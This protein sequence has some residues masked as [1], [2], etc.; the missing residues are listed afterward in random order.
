MEVAS[1]SLAFK[2]KDRR[3]RKVNSVKNFVEKLDPEFWE[4]KDPH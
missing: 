1:L 3:C 4:K 2:G